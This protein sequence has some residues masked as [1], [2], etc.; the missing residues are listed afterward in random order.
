[1][2][3]GPIEHAA[4]IA[5]HLGRLG[6]PDLAPLAPEDVA[7]LAAELRDDEYDAGTFLFRTG[8][9]P[10]RIHIVRSGAVELSC[11]FKGRPVV[12]QILRPGDVVGDVPLFL[13]MTES[14]DAVALEDSRVLSVDSLTLH[15]LLARRPQLAWRWMLSVSS[16]MA[17]AQARLVELLAGGLEA[18]M[19]LVLLRRADDGVVHL[20]Q[21]I[22]AELVGGRRPSVNRV[23]KRLESEGLLRLCYGHV[24]ILDEPGLAALAGLDRA[25]A[26]TEGDDVVL[27]R[28]RCADRRGRRG[29]PPGL[30]PQGPGAPS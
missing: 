29:G 20:R 17:S 30:P 10:S 4:W 9:A 16:R 27:R 12:L 22:L 25:S 1:M 7:E 21:S 8:Q 5:G 13:R 15:R 6:Q 19:A 24:E 14:F 28:A 26:T 2:P 23:L 11:A 18:Q 3:D